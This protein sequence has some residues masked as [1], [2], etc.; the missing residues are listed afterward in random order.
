MAVLCGLASG[1]ASR[2]GGVVPSEEGPRGPGCEACGGRRDAETGVGV[3]SGG[4]DRCG[5]RRVETLS[6]VPQPA[7]GEA[8]QRRGAVTA[9]ARE[10]VEVW[11]GGCAVAGV[12]KGERH[13]P[14][15]SR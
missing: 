5:L 8:S 11:P 3:V 12:K 10:A 15:A 13:T 2:G 9:S 1:Q 7:G 4:R 6:G 14:L